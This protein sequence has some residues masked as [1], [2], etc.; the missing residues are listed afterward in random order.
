MNQY[1]TPLPPCDERTRALQESVQFVDVR[2]PSES[3]DS[4]LSGATIYRLINSNMLNKILILKNRS[5]C[6][7]EA[8]NA[9]RSQDAL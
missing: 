6:I 2:N 4:A 3:A 5:F 7:T 8:V 9:A 1:L